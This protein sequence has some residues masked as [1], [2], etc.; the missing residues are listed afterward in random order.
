MHFYT[1]HQSIK[2]KIIN[3]LYNILKN[4]NKILKFY[5]F[6]LLF[7]SKKQVNILSFLF[8]SSSNFSFSIPIP[9]KLPSIFL[10]IFIENFN[11][12]MYYLGVSIKD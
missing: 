10:T 2:I 1:D 7:S 9:S 4:K 5:F 11:N 3:Y 12:N 6:F 8:I